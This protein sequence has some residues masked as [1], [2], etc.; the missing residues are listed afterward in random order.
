MHTHLYL[1]TPFSEYNTYML[2]PLKEGLLFMP[3]QQV[4]TLGV[5][6]EFQILDPHSHDLSSS[7]TQLLQETQPTLGDAVQN[8]MLL[9]QIE[10]ACRGS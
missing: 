7:A 8:E 1:L 5:E 3:F 9:S 10:T 2:F 4:Y 6:E